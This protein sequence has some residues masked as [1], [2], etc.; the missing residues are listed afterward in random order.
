MHSSRT[1]DCQS[2]YSKEASTHLVFL[3]FPCLA[4]IEEL[5]A[6]DLY[7]PDAHM[8]MARLASLVLACKQLHKAGFLHV[9]VPSQVTAALF[10]ISLSLLCQLVYV[11]VVFLRHHYV[12]SLLRW[13]LEK[14]L[15][16]TR[17]CCLECKC[18][19]EC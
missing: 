9:V 18:N 5:C 12:Q 14:Y 3:C 10:Y 17:H 11:C 7:G 8:K 16:Q 19:S 4:S 13:E 15:L 6:V 1:N 2:P